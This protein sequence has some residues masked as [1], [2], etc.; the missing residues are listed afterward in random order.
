MG[1]DDDSAR[2]AKEAADVVTRA[3]CAL[4]FLDALAS[5][6]RFEALK[7]SLSEARMR[8]S[9]RDAAEAWLQLCDRQV[10]SGGDVEQ[11]EARTLL[12]IFREMRDRAE[13]AGV[14]ARV[15]E[16][17]ELAMRHFRSHLMKPSR[18]ILRD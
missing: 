12:P 13:S 11:Q 17:A 6:E 2:R 1:Q 7:A 3:W 5:G 8:E 16:L 9:A 18:G 4:D 15:R 14:D 10:R